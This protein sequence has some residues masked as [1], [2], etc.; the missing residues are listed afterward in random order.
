[1][2]E[3]RVSDWLNP[4]YTVRAVICH[5]RR[6][7]SFLLQLKSKG[8]FGEGYWNAPGGKIESEET[9]EQAAKREVIEE[10]GLIPLKLQNVGFLEFYF[11]ER[12]KIPDWA[13]EVFV[14][15][16]HEGDITE[17]TLEGELRW[18][19]RNEIPYDRMW[20]D[21]RYWLPGLT[22]NPDL[23]D[24]KKFHGSFIFSEDSKKLLSWT[25]N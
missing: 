15:T 2:T 6:G 4:P 19:H 11:G 23:K 14:C 9:P 7:D 8:R 3:R 24:Q 13:A 12:K 16:E 17:T 5:I 21:D 18:F 10:T 20:A 22:D 1:M 25:L